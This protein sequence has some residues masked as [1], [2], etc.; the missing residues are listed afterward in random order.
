MR[1]CGSYARTA[2]YQYRHSL[3][4]CRKI[5]GDI[6][7]VRCVGFS[8]HA[9][10]S[11]KGPSMST[12]VFFTT[13]LIDGIAQ[14]PAA[15]VQLP[16]ETAPEHLDDGFGVEAVVSGVPPSATSFL[17]GTRS[18]DCSNWDVWFQM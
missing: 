16:R 18:K 17:D 13:T 7:R 3:S 4:M 11:S 1:A 10:S 15:G 8:A 5:D 6:E 14:G 9:S 2:A 12:N